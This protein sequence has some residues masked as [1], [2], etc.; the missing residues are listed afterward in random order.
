[1]DVLIICTNRNRQPLPVVP[2]GA[3]IVAEAAERDGHRVRLL[4][5]MFR[6]DP[7]AAIE[8]ALRGYAPDVIGLSVRNLD[9]ND[10]Q[11]PVEFVSQLREIAQAVARWSP[12]PIVLGGP[13]VGVMPEP[14][15]RLTGASFAIL[16][17][18]ET[19]FPA[20]LRAL[21]RGGPIGETPR[22]AWL[23]N[24]RFQVGPNAPAEL[25]N[26]AIRPEF[27]RWLNLPAYLSRMATVP[28][29]SKRG[30]PF[31]CIYC[32]Y[33]I[34]EGRQYR[35]AP[36]EEVADAVQRL[37]AMGYRDIEFVDNVFN[38]PYDHALAVCDCLA[39]RRHRARLTS[40]ELNPAFVDDQ[41]LKSME[42]A[43]FIG[44]GL[45]AESA[46]DPVLA[47]MQKGYTAAQVEKAAEAVRRSRLPCFWLFLLGGP[48]ETEA[49]VAE[50]I[51]FAR[52][53]LRPG[54][55]A[56]F[57]VGI[58]IYPGT[59]IDRLARREGV[60][61]PQG[62]DWLKPVFYFSPELDLSRT[63]DRVRRAA[64]ENLT[65]LHSAS[66][67]HPWLPAINR[68]CRRLPLRPP[69]WRHT[70]TIRRVVRT[71]GRDI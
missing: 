60:V 10:M 28:L 37:A 14:L 54:D 55:V 3:C 19:A 51:A 17:D 33:G 65:L 46:A 1:V 68:L 13:A 61:P 41:L 21:N 45:T 15:L 49:T 7:L 71:L 32:T 34:S 66:L 50:T 69:L 67:S 20:L 52:R 18:G 9:N 64:A 16:G 27:H 39:S 6:R 5:L 2:Y 24:G 48:G 62:Q 59:E 40:I 53:T 4:D 63:M 8:Q 44:I 36:P 22:T 47:G 58:R 56:F 31:T 26:A 42:Q 12:A 25:V 29:Q 23:E 57:N 30:C 43:G 70:R 35:L 11:A 38:A